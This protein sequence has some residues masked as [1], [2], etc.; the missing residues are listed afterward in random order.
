MRVVVLGVEPENDFPAIFYGRETI[1]KIGPCAAWID[2]FVG[3]LCLFDKV[4]FCFIH[5]FALC[6][7]PALLQILCQIKDAIRR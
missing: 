6:A 2:M 1:G 7:Y 4:L 3:F 5:N